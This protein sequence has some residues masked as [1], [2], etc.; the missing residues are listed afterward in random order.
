MNK[1]EIIAKLDSYPWPEKNSSTMLVGFNVSQAI[2]L[3]RVKVGNNVSHPI[4]TIMLPH[5]EANVT[6]EYLEEHF[7]NYS[8]MEFMSYEEFMSKYK[9]IYDAQRKL[10][11]KKILENKKKNV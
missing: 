5:I 3:H 4:I 9:D 7:I 6:F 10:S 11:S 2:T 8:I 1:E